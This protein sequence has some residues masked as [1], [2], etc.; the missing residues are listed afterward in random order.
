MLL[1]FKQGAL[2]EIDKMPIDQNLKERI[3]EEIR[4]AGDL[5]EAKRLFSAAKEVA[6]RG[7]VRDATVWPCRD[8][9]TQVWQLAFYL[10]AFSQE[11]LT[12]FLGVIELVLWVKKGF[13]AQDSHE[14]S[15]C[16]SNTRTGGVDN[17]SGKGFSHS[18]PPRACDDV[19]GPSPQ[20]VASHGT[21]EDLLAKARPIAPMYANPAE[22]GGQGA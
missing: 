3:K 13:A 7:V 9:S 22:D 2:W 1:E 8:F 15:S 16:M 20:V 17:A 21:R 18:G 19:T 11:I 12:R 4:L 6:Q 14:R 10:E 5:G